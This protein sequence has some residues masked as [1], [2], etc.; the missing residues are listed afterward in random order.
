LAQKFHGPKSGIDRLA[1][2]KGHILF[3]HIGERRNG[4]RFAINSQS[5]APLGFFGD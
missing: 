1:L 3:G 5:D 2:P 4:N